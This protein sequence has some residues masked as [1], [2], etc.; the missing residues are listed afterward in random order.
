MDIEDGQNLHEE[1]RRL[2]GL[3]NALSHLYADYTGGTMPGAV[4]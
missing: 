2:K 4:R 1:I 3:L